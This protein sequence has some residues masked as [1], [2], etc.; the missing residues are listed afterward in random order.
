[1]LVYALLVQD[2]LHY[3]PVKAGLA[4]VPMAATFLIASL[5][6]PRLVARYGRKVITAGALVQ[7]AGLV[8]LVFSLEATWPQVGVSQLAAGLLV[9]GFGQGLVM[10]PLIRV[11]LS[12]VPP[13]EAGVGSGVLTTT[14]QVSLAV[15]VGSLGTLFVTLEPASRF[16]ALHAAVLIL[17]VQAVIAIGIAV[18]S[19][20]LSSAPRS[21]G[22]IAGRDRP[23]LTKA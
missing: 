12:E 22:G 13:S 18:A 23:V 5:L 20:R 8:L 11:V 15:G 21:H 3:S 1:M 14:Q 16:G 19:R 10:P 17:G 6:M 4:L 9:M 7:L 2:Q